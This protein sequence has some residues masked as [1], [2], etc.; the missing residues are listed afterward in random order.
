MTDIVKFEQF[1]L[2]SFYNAIPTLGNAN[3]WF[4]WSQKVKEFIGISAVADDGATPPE[5]EEE[6]QKW[7]HRQKLYSAMI[8]AKLT[9]DAAQRINAFNVTRVQALLQAVKAKF[10]PEGSGTYVQLQKRYMSLS[11]ATCGSVQAL[12]AEIRKI[13][14]EKL[15][16]DPDCVTSEIERIFFFLQALGPEYENF[17]D[18]TFRQADM[19]NVRDEAGN[20]TTAAP[21]F[22]SIENKAIEEEHRKGQLGKQPDPQVLPTFALTRKSG[23]RKITPSVDGTTCIIETIQ[24][25]PY[26]SFCQKPYHVEAR[27]FKKNP[28]LRDQ[29]K[30]DKARKAKSDNTRTDTRNSSKKRSSTDDEDDNEGGPRDPKRPTFMATMAS[31]EDVNAA[32]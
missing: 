32:Y 1:G 27:C 14:A 13:H 19:V 22:D 9:H 5:D 29:G 23:D 7:T 28:K 17:R 16:L 31:E 4:K 3:D 24:N 12:G 21:T 25:A 6:A 26:C 20:I 18:H 11:R 2:N 15:L 10:K 8:A 30:D